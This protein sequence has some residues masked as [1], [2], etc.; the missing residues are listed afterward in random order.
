[1]ENI[2]INISKNKLSIESS[3]FDDNRSYDSFK[4]ESDDGSIF[5]QGILLNKAEIIK[6][7]KVDNFEKYLSKEII[8]DIIILKELRGSYYGYFNDVKNK[9]LYIF[10]DHLGTKNIYYYHKSDELI[11]T[12][13]Y[14]NFLQDKMRLNGNRAKMLLSYGY[15]IDDNT[16]LEGVKKLLPGSILSVDYT[17]L[18]S[19]LVESVNYFRF[20]DDKI[21]ISSED[22]IEKLDELFKVAVRRQFEKDKEHNKKH[23]VALSGGLDS[24]MTVWVAHSMGYTE[25]INFTFSQ[26]DYL[27]ETIAKKIATDLKHEWIFKFLDNGN[28][29]YSVDEITDISGGNV[30]Y[31]G[32]AHS[33]S[34]LKLLNFDELGILHSGQ[35]GDVIIGSFIKNFDSDQLNSLGAAYSEL[36]LKLYSYQKSYKSFEEREIDLMYQR[37]INGANSGLMLINSYTE[38]FSPFYDIDFM[39]FCISLP[40]KMRMNHNLYKKWILQK[41]PDAANYVWET[42]KRK[43]NTREPRF[44]I[45]GRKIYLSDLKDSFLRKLHLKKV[46]IATK[47]NMNPLQYWYETNFHMRYFI[48][49]YY[50]DNIDLLNYDEEL[51]DITI[52]LFE[53]G[54]AVEKNQVLSLLS[55]LKAINKNT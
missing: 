44:N 50:L 25:Q 3:D 55:I 33:N 10:N 27:D 8:K 9:K 53:E 31:Y 6:N 11:I 28:F 35:L 41:Y 43:I 24:R 21:N 48:D 54:S 42:T 18:Y 38:T 23:L 30:L 47:N 49:Q 13:K 12:T 20:S 26:S 15:M 22:A 4:T 39:E 34:F 16:I 7:Y 19:P 52:K 46:P 37:A 40:I 2:L 17:S 29:L 1:M 51:K 32:L 14:N 36:G 5:L 45:L